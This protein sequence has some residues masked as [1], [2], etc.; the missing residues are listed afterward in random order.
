MSRER[1]DVVEFERRLGALLRDRRKQREISQETL[2][3]QLGINQSN[4]SKI[5]AGRRRLQVVELFRWCEVLGLD[6]DQLMV[7]V[8]GLWLHQTAHKSLWE[9]K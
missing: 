4:V 2:A 1:P 9:A 6:A 8:A 3:T 5:E 7:E